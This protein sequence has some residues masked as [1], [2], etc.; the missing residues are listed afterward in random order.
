MKKLPKMLVAS[1]FFCGLSIA[2]SPAGAE[3]SS[4]NKTLQKQEQEALR[5]EGQQEFQKASDLLQQV[6]TKRF[7]TFSKDSYKKSRMKA[8]FTD[9]SVPHAAES[10]AYV[11]DLERLG[12]NSDRM[13]AFEKGGKAFEEAYAIN[14]DCFGDQHDKTVSALNQLAMHYERAGNYAAAE[15]SA[16]KCVAFAYGP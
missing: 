10:L 2:P 14:K 11:Q 3:D 15:Q 16:K 1:L 5:L 12:W 8:G 6:L 4:Y 13:K 7:K 9:L